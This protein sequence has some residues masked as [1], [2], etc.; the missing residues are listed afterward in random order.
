MELPE[1]TIARGIVHPWLVGSM[2]GNPFVAD[3][4]KP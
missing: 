1:G 4:L 2:A 3:T